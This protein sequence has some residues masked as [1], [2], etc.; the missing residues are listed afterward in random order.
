MKSILALAT[1]LFV[2]SAFAQNTDSSSSGSGRKHM[3]EFNA[4][5]SLLANWAFTKS[6]NRGQKADNDSEVSFS[7]GY[8]YSIPNMPRIQVGGRLIYAKNNELT[9]SESYGA[10]VG[11]VYNHIEDLSNSIYASLYLG[12][13]WDQIYSTAAKSRDENRVSTLAI[14]KRFDLKHWGIDHLTYSP[15]IALVNQNSTTESNVE[16]YQA[17]ELRILQFSAFF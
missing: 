16:Y 10:Q 3:I 15:E 5:T 12:M 6:K 8:A 4:D 11:V 14:G 1:A 13:R 17:V 2:G 7:G 9:D